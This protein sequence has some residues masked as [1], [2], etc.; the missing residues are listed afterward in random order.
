LRA[1]LRS[2]GA[3]RAGPSSLSP[4]PSAPGN[5]GE[6]NLA[7]LLDLVALGTVADVVGLDNNNRILVQQGLLRI[8]PGRL[9]PG[10]AALVR[11]AGGDRRRATTQDLGNPLAPRLNAAGGLTDMALGI[12]CLTTAD[13][14]RARAIAGELDRLNR[15]RRTI[16]SDMQDEARTAI[17]NTDWS[18]NFSLSL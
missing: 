10:V 2:R 15:E 11:T 1:E 4:D 3:F 16:E 14:S 7:A 13:A 6:P 9:Q 18:E 5:S 12:E 17:D 8:R